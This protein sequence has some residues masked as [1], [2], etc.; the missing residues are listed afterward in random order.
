MSEETFV[1]D[2]REGIAKYYNVNGALHKEI[3]FKD[4]REEGRGYEYG[5]DG[6]IVVF[7]QYGAGL[8]RKREDINQ[9]DAMGLR[10][11][12][13]KEFHSNGKVKWE[14]NF[15]DD[16]RQGLF[17]EYDAQGSLKDLVK[18]DA[19]VVDTQAQEAQMLDIRKTYHPNGKVASMGS[20]SRTG[21]KEGLFREFNS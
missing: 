12:P 19:G 14:G 21:T 2:R 4:G 18:Y 20:S 5:N 7:L 8:L 6:R 1:D 11:G 16:Q 13:W 3:P 9:L 15:I 17:K 10:Q